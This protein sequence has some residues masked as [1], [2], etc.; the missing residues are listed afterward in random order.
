[1]R[2]EHW[3]YTIPLRLRSLF[4][5][6][7]TDLELD[8]ELR[9][10]VERKTEVYLSKGLA[11][12]EARRQALLEM[13]G[14]E[15]RKEECREARRVNWI[16]DLG[17]D[18]RY[19]LRG[20][21]RTPL[22][23]LTV[24]AT[25]AL[26]LGI[27]TALFTVFDA[28][29]LRPVPV[30]D[31]NSVYRFTWTNRGGTEHSFSWPEF[32]AFQDSNPAFSEA[33]AT[34]DLFARVKD[35]PLVGELVTA[36]YFRMLGVSA[37]AGRTL[38]PEDG[39][40]PGSAP[41][42]VL[43]YSAW[44]N[45]L[46]GD[47]NIIGKTI[48]I[49]GYPLQV[50]GIT[51]PEFTGLSATARD[52]W[53]PITMA[54][55]LEDGPNLFG[56]DHP[57]RLDIV[58]RLRTGFTAKQA[59][60]A[61][62]VWAQHATGEKGRDEKAVR[63]V[64]ESR[65]TLIPLTPQL[66]AAAAPLF[67][68]FLLVLLI[69]CANIANM[70]LARA[71]ARQR[72]IGVRL[73]LGAT[74]MRLARQL[75]TE[76]LVLSVP[77]ALVG[78]VFSETAI[79]FGQRWLFTVMPLDLAQI[80]TVPLLQPDIRVFGLLFGASV[81]SAILS[82]LVP[83][84]Q[85][86]RLDVS[87]ATKGEFTAELRPIKFRN[88][89]VTSEITACV[90]LLICTGLSLRASARMSKQEVGFATR[91]I[92]ELDINEKY[93][94]RILSRLAEE[95]AIRAV[96]EAESIPLNG[97]LPKVPVVARDASTLSV[98]Y[99]FVSPNFF[100]VLG[101]AILNGRNFTEEEARGQEAV[102]IVSQRTALQFWPGRSAVGQTLRITPQ[103]G[104][105]LKSKVRRFPVV[106]IIGV[107]ADIASC[108]LT[109]GMDSS[110]LYLPVSSGDTGT[111]LLVQADG[112]AE[113]ARQT[114]ETD[115][116][117]INTDAIE[118][119]H[120][121]DTFRAAGVFPFRVATAVCMVVGGLALLLALSGVYGVLSYSVSQRTR[122]I[123]IRL[124]IGAAPVA[125]AGLV[126]KQSMRLALIGGVAGSV[127]AFGVWRILSSRLFFMSTF[128][129]VAFFVGALVPLAAAGMATY[130]PARRAMHVDPMVA[131]R[132]E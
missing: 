40:S 26:A 100:G 46:G 103:A 127:L 70:M 44:Q 12:E 45:K 55:Q 25:I 96:A 21:R 119:L 13:G 7:E 114:L 73:S 101:V 85:A 33:A 126:L 76:S 94:S 62:M 108:C 10:H 17:Q 18:L 57:N 28:Y 27:N 36:N 88:A 93:R 99:N 31:P 89:L 122:E 66:V 83:A 56:S 91:G 98:S 4:R 2:P 48:V 37:V 118:Q 50:V 75:L 41:V 90:M 3:I 77:A 81:V 130:I 65:A 15:K 39:A 116:S 112:S 59:E 129:G 8:D 61:L 71:V 132:Y 74:R 115:L 106:R 123:G 9:D 24:V 52:F 53:I 110:L 1:M 87:Q 16:Q 95:P 58:G 29:V 20:F 64:L 105:G 38:L 97:M 42:V 69:A 125:V 92:L 113:R 109:Q 19:G 22:F 6:I 35:Y 82:G 111:S 72:E 121:L 23:V 104:L 131:L 5:R 51:R 84:L 128:D 68:A 63:T 32:E 54:S 117:A 120:T 79:H 107:A 30:H 43:S 78:L 47:P 60:A 80:V 102:A 11:L 124:A 86:T 34:R 49:R 67:V 14:I